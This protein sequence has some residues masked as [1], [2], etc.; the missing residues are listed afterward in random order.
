MDFAVRWRQAPG[1]LVL[2]VSGELDVA[3]APVLVA[4]E[5]AALDVCRHVVLDLGDLAFIDATGLGALLTGHRY[6]T[7]RGAVLELTAVPAPVRRL[8]AITNLAGILTAAVP[9]PR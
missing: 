1:C 8:L 3:T 4:A 5:L 2:D 9:G 6:A 7:D